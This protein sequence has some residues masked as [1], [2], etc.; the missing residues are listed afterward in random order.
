MLTFKHRVDIPELMDNPELDCTELRNAYRDLERV[1]TFLGGHNSSLEALKRI[2]TPSISTIIDMGCG[3]GSFLRVVADF[4]RG[5]QRRINLIGWDNNP[6][7][8]ELAREHEKDYPEIAYE[9][10]DVLKPGTLPDNCLITCNLFLHHFST[11]AVGSILKT[12]M[13][14]GAKGIMIND[15]HRNGAAYYLFKLFGPIFIKTSTARYDGAVSVRRGWR[16][17]ELLNIAETLPPN[18]SSLHWKWAFRWI[19][20]LEAH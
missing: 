17:E 11:E 1:N 3:D 5:S 18:Q 2:L 12:W 14:A 16:R 19:M 15:L 8:L 4:C 6:K 20:T 10:Q 7:S 13:E 9:L